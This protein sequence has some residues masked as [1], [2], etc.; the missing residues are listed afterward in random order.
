ML[1][2]SV[3]LIEILTG[4]VGVAVLHVAAL[5]VDGTRSEPALTMPFAVAPFATEETADC[6]ETAQG[7]QIQYKQKDN[8]SDE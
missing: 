5:R 8:A 7:E 2:W 1:F 6:H 3:D 4:M